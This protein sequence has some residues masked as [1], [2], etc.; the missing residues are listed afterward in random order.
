MI[1]LIERSE[2]DWA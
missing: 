2:V 1:N